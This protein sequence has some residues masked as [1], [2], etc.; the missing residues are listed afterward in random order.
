MKTRRLE[1]T[2]TKFLRRDKVKS[3]TLNMLVYMGL[4]H[5]HSTQR[6]LLSGRLS[7]QAKG[8]LK[9]CI[10][11]SFPGDVD[12]AGPKTILSS[13]GGA[14]RDMLLNEKMENREEGIKVDL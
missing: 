6:S 3:S 7:Q 13:K 1:K 11:N 8:R 4:L 10:F 5:P 12:A 9:L 2:R 14:E